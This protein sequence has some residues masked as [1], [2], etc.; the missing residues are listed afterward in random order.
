MRK[1]KTQLSPPAADPASV[2][3]EVIIGD[4]VCR[5]ELSP[6]TF[7]WYEREARRRGVTVADLL[8]DVVGSFLAHWSRLN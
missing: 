5:V 6:V 1:K 8:H 4:E 2:P 7:R 3:V